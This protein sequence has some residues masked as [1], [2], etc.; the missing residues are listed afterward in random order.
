[1]TAINADG[2]Q[3]SADDWS[4]G[5]IVLRRGSSIGAGATIV[6]GVVVGEFAMVAA[7]AVVTRDVPNHG[8]VAGSP[9]R[10]IGWVC[11]CGF[12]HA[13]TSDPSWQCPDCG[14]RVEVPGAHDVA[15]SDE[16]D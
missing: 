2:T 16:Q 14:G 10:L 11:A 8:L 7:G 13:L 12:R 9:A 1:V 5:R 4:V 15:S 3:K 6:T